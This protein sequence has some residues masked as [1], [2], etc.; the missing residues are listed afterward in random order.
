MR[1]SFFFRKPDLSGRDDFLL[2]SSAAR[3]SAISTPGA[4]AAE[5]T[6]ER[7]KDSC[8]LSSVSASS[9]AGEL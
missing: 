4:E 5:H 7:D 9:E 6:E 1:S 2:P 3:H 8:N